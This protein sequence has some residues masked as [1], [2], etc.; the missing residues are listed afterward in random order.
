MSHGVKKSTFYFATI[1]CNTLFAGQ[2]RAHGGRYESWNVFINSC[3]DSEKEDIWSEE[4][5]TRPSSPEVIILP[6][7]NPIIN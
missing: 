2:S 4:E 5:E 6:N 7:Y 1:C 3:F